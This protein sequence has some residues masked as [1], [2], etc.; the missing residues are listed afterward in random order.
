[1]RNNLKKTILKKRIFD[2]LT[3]FFLSPLLIPLL[4]ILALLVFIFLG[5]PVIFRHQRPGLNGKVFTLFKFRTMTNAVDNKGN[6]LA[7][8]RRLT[9]FGQF[10]RAT[11][12]D[13]IPEIFNVLLGQMSLIG[14]RPLLI[15]YLKEYNDEQ[16]NRHNLLPGI[17]G[18]AQVSGRNQI[19]WHKRFELD[20]YYVRNWSFFLDMKILLLTLRS[21]VK[22]KD[23]TPEKSQFMPGFKRDE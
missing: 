2:Y 5:R 22:A 16:K 6:L 9:K 14:P 15:S 4:I 19:D 7:D 23:I 21:V 1:M 18:L 8:E 3:I 12:L 10:L 11:S 20:V 13:E 17:T